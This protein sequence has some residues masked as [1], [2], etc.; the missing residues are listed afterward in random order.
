MISSYVVLTSVLMLLPGKVVVLS[1]SNRPTLAEGTLRLNQNISQGTKKILLLWLSLQQAIL[2]L[3][4]AYTV[5]MQ[6][7]MTGQEGHS[8]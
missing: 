5:V 3:T 6:A 7:Q 4:S 2:N 8:Y 1:P